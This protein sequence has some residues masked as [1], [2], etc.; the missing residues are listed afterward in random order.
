M[1][2]GP[3]PITAPRADNWAPWDATSGPGTDDASGR[4][5]K[6]P[7]GPAD[8]STGEPTGGDFPDGPGGWQQ[9]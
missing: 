3:G 8:M 7:G 5:V 6:L 4:W 2:V 9:C 1:D